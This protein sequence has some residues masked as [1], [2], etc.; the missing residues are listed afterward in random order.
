MALL[1]AACGGMAGL[2]PG[3]LP[4]DDA[5][6]SGDAPLDSTVPSQDSG[7]ADT[8]V[9]PDTA[10]PPDTRVG[11]TA[12]APD[13]GRPDS[14][15]PDTGRPDTSAPDTGAPDTGVPD[16]AVLDTG[17]P[18]T[19]APD[20]GPVDTG[21]VD[22]GP[23]DTGMTFP[24]GVCAE[25]V[26][27]TTTGPVMNL[28]TINFNW[29]MA[30]FDRRNGLLFVFIEDTERQ[31]VALRFNDYLTRGGPA[32]GDTVDLSRF[33]SRT[34]PFFV[35]TISGIMTE[36]MWRYE[37]DYLAYEGQAVFRELRRE[38]PIGTRLRVEFRNVRARQVQTLTDR[39]CRDAPNGARMNITSLNLDLM[40][41]DLCTDSDCIEWAGG[42]R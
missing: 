29:S 39:T 25:P 19:G 2:P 4:M 35:S 18:D 38:N 41:N 7:T 20:T 37:R 16:T 23:A 8:A 9:A 13:T 15:V 30:C 22:T 28:P 1:T 24:A 33:R 42:C 32:G 36:P 26:A 27:A 17:R 14:A 5:A 11:D 31:M 12:V 21:V 10:V 3:E 34:T 6:I 40:V